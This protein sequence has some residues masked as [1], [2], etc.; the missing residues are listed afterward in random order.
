MSTPLDIRTPW[1]ELE[2]RYRAILEEH[3][4][5]QSPVEFISYIGGRTSCLPPLMTAEKRLAV[6]KWRDEAV[7]VEQKLTQEKTSEAEAVSDSSSGDSSDTSDD[8]Y[9]EVLVVKT[10]ERPKS[11]LAEALVNRLRHSALES[12]G[13]GDVVKS[14]RTRRDSYTLEEPSPLLKAYMEKYGGLDMTDQKVVSP[15]RP[16]K[17]SLQAYLTDL[18]QMPQIE[19]RQV[20]VDERLVAVELLANNEDNLDEVIEKPEVRSVESRMDAA[21]ER[22]FPEN[23]AESVQ[24]NLVTAENSQENV[25]ETSLSDQLGP[26]EWRFLTSEAS[27]DPKDPKVDFSL[28]SSA[29]R[30]VSI[31]VAEEEDESVTLT[32]SVLFQPT[33][34]NSRQIETAVSSLAQAQQKRLQDLL[35]EQKRQRQELA[36]MFRLQQQEL[37]S[38]ILNTANSMQSLERMQQLQEPQGPQQPQEPQEPQQPQEPQEPPEPQ[39][40]QEP[41]STQPPRSASPV[42]P[43]AASRLRPI[44]TLPPDFSTPEVAFSPEMHA[45]FCLVTAAARGFLTRRLLRT[46]RVQAIIK[47]LR[48]T[49]FMALRL[50]SEPTAAPE[51]VELHRRLL[52]Q[53]NRDSAEI[54]RIFFDLS[55]VERMGILA[56]D[57]E[58]RRQKQLHPELPKKQMLSSATHSRLEQKAKI[59]ELLDGKENRERGRQRRTKSVG[60]ISGRN[61]H[62]SYLDQ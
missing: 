41:Q 60:S 9:S 22:L 53:L 36:K 42:V 10:E 20:K 37:V 18:T 4:E 32:D 11:K 16:T 49:M 46:L 50:H 58:L 56:A 15:R 8:D 17:E 3:E 51:D 40:P 55:V 62:T 30:S 39:E 2:R 1:E 13:D 29:F 12:G 45:K 27:E 25:A 33:Q 14:P 43:A 21:E 6:R 7:K 35:S 48:D 57:Y 31:E 34:V 59:R 5:R 38:Q 54:H 28:A 19:S 24:Q 23:E 52:Q 61:T 47:S 26:A 44:S